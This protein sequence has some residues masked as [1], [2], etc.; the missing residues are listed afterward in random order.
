[1]AKANEVD[2]EERLMIGGVRSTELIAPVAK[3]TTDPD[4]IFAAI[5]RHRQSRDELNAKVDIE[6]D[7]PLWAAENAASHEVF[8]MRP[9]TLAGTRAKIKFWQDIER[10]DAG[11]MPPKRVAQVLDTLLPEHLP[12][13]EDAARSQANAENNTKQLVNSEAFGRWLDAEPAINEMVA[14][15]EVLSRLTMEGGVSRNAM[16]FLIYLLGDKVQ[17]VYGAWRAVFPPVKK[18]P[19]S[20]HSSSEAA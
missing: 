14:V 7:D 11:Y 18:R 4:P 5:E 16:D 9:L 3:A 6:N 17:E 1:M 13:S 8:E 10:G 19:Q 20:E 15:S 2:T 12:V